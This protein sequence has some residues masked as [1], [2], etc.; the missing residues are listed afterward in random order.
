M[1]ALEGVDAMLHIVCPFP[2]E[3]SCGDF[4][5]RVLFLSYISFF[6]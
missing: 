4:Q 2:G 5:G 1:K 6:K 3:E